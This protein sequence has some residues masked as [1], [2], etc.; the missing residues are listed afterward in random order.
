MPSQ[1]GQQC[2]CGSRVT[3]PLLQGQQ[4]HLDNGKDACTLT[5]AMAPLLQGQESQWLQWQRHLRIDGNNAIS[6][7]AT[8]SAQQQAMRATTLA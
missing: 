3:M 6:M 7:R 4:C 8:M 5:T 2:H 1:Q